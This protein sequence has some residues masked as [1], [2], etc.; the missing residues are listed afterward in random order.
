MKLYVAALLA[1]IVLQAPGLCD[2]NNTDNI[3]STDSTGVDR[4]ISE[5]A[6]NE[7]E[8][9]LT[10]DNITICGIAETL[11]HDLTFVSTTHPLEKVRVSGQKIS[12]A[13]INETQVAYRVRSSTSGSGT[14][15][16]TGIWI[17]L[18][19]DSEGAVGGGAMP[20]SEHQH[21]TTDT[22]AEQQ[23]TPGFGIGALVAMMFVAYL[24]VRR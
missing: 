13:V 9:T 7:F 24:C 3:D 19:N 8:V 18:L 10:L 20:H 6:S 21:Q 2:A 22:E 23:N 12:F 1:M 17:D 11:P 14:P 16:I 5:V 4:A 15:E